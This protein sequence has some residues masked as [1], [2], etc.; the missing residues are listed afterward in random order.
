MNNMIINHI[1]NKTLAF[2]SLITIIFS[3]QALNAQTS[4]DAHAGHAH[5]VEQATSNIQQT[6]VDNHT[7]EED[8]Q[9]VDNHDEH[10]DEMGLTLSEKQLDAFGITLK[11]TRLG[12]LAQIIRLPGEVVF[13]QDNLAEIHP[14]VPGIAQAVNVTVGDKVKTGQTLVV[15]QSRELAEARSQYLAA[16]ARLDLQKETLKRDK[17]LHKQNLMADRTL[18]VK[19]QALREAEIELQLADQQLHAYGY[20]HKQILKTDKLN[21]NELTHYDL[22]SPIDGIVIQRTI[23]RGEIFGPDADEAPFVIANTESVWV[24]LVVY[25]KDLPRIKT[26]MT[27]DIEFG[28]NLPSA[29]GVIS[30]ISPAIDEDTRTAKARVILDNKSNHWRPGL[31]VT[32]YIHDEVT[33]GNVIVPL[34]SIH[35][36][37]DEYVIFVKHGDEFEPIH[38]EL[39]KQS[40]THVQILAGLKPGQTYVSSGAFTLKA[41]MQKGAFGDGH[42]H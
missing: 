15:L 19:K 32:A 34:A 18:M 24:D 28:H 41:Q 26:G 5:E 40:Q 42:N 14:V 3:S 27:V 1:F 6:I 37:G 12:N 16:L 31:F 4:G 11:Q 21:D 39:G 7:D 13:N 23:T 8:L 2:L 17:E 20:T 9:A 30:F 35:E 10:E 22:R 29:T 33:S 38:V 25:Q 36:I